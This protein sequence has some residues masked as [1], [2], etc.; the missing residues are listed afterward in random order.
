[1]KLDVPKAII[2][3]AIIVAAGFFFN[4]TYERQL[5]YNIC[6]KMFKEHP[7]SGYN[8]EKLQKKLC[9]WHIYVQGKNRPDFVLN[10]KK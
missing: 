1:M 2:I 7:P 9:K 5:S 8:D 6:V 3:G 10:F 4:S